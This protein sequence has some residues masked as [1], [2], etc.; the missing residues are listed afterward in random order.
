MGGRCIGAC[1]AMGWKYKGCWKITGS[2]V[3]F[4]SSSSSSKYSLQPQVVDI[5]AIFAVRC[6]T[7]DSGDS[8][9]QV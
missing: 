9:S 8:G 4:F 7:V 5:G 6:G 2:K 3:I 1:T